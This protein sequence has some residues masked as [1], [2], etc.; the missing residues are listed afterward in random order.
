MLKKLYELARLVFSF[1]QQTQKN[2]IELPGDRFVAIQPLEP[3]DDD[4]PV[5]ELLESNAAFRALLAKWKT[6]PPKPFAGGPVS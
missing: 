1:G 6:S 5:D 4:S 2:L 3:G